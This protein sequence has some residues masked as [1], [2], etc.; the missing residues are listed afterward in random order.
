M[1]II[2]WEYTVRDGHEAEFEKTY[3]PNGD[4]EQL[5]K[6]GEGYLGTDL[7]HTQIFPGITSQSTIG[8]LSKLMK[9]FIRNIVQ[10]TE[11]WI[12]VVIP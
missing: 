9:L 1:Y 6:Q 5:F 2:V 11:H 12:S 7:V 10:H 3:G 4:W 8:F